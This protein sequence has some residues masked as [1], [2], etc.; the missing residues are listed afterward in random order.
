MVAVAVVLL[1]AAAQ[2]PANMQPAASVA[3]CGV[4]VSLVVSLVAASSSRSDSRSGGGS[5]TTGKNSG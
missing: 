3:V 1:F 5:G 4:V 2:Q